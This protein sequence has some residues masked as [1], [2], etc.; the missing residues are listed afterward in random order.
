MVVRLSADLQE[1]V[2]SNENCFFHLYPNGRPWLL[3]GIKRARG[4]K[5]VHR[6]R[7][8]SRHRRD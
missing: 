5:S 4:D 1:S 6:F 7:I 2:E 3:M 8:D